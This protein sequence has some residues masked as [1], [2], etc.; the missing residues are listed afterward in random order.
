LPSSI[1]LLYSIAA[2]W[3][4]LSSCLPSRSGPVVTT[5]ESPIAGLVLGVCIHRLAEWRRNWKRYLVLGC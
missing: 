3:G 5:N 2:I 1:W 4:G